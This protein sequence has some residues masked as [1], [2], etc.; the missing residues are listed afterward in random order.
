MGTG[1]GQTQFESLV[2]CRAYTRASE[3]PKRGSEKKEL[4]TSQVIVFC[5]EIIKPSV[6]N[7]LA[8]YP[9]R[10]EDAVFQ[11]HRK[12]KCECLKYEGIIKQ[13]KSR[14]PAG[15][16][17][18][19][20][21]ER[22]DLAVYNGEVTIGQMYNLL[23]TCSNDTGSQFPF[24]LALQ[25]FRTT[26]SWSLLLASSTRALNPKVDSNVNNSHNYNNS[27]SSSQV[28][29]LIDHNNADANNP[30]TTFDESEFGCK[31]NTELCLSQ[32]TKRARDQ[33]KQVAAL[34]KV[35]EPIDKLAEAA[36]K[37]VKLAQ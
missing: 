21:T 17:M 28:S 16:P 27:N 12:A 18:E 20:D 24:Y 35:A 4:F 6:E 22:A 13:V 32:G 11:R 36:T 10:S 9:E 31:N 5:K 29:N 37:M 2:A 3:D 34:H 33:S 7:G 14:N 19:K 25:F 23:T 15:V 1:K 8:V 30:S 26:H